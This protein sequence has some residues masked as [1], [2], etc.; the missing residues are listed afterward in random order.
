MKPT[1]REVDWGM[2]AVLLGLVIPTARIRDLVELIAND[3]ELR[4][5]VYNAMAWYNCG[6]GRIN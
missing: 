2:I 5:Q 3:M 1:E 6:L 4:R